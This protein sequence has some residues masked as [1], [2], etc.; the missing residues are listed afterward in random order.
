V[1]TGG[2]PDPA[3]HGPRDLGAWGPLAVVFGL[4]LAMALAGAAV[5]FTI[6]VLG[7]A[8]LFEGPARIVP[9]ILSAQ[10]AVGG[11]ALV[12]G[13]VPQAGWRARL[14][15]VTGDLRAFDVPVLAL[16]TPFLFVVGALLGSLLFEDPGSGLLDLQAAFLEAPLPLRLLFLVLGTVLPALTEEALF[17]GYVQRRLLRVWSAPPAVLFS[18]LFFAAVHGEPMH[19]ASVFPVGLWLGIVA[20]RTGSLW[21]GIAGHFVG[22]L[23][24]FATLGLATDPDGPGW[25]ALAVL[26]LGS[27]PFF[28]LSCVRLWQ[29]G[30][31]R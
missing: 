29:G 15:F 14:G 23:L 26:L 25:G 28:L 30:A 3:A 17:R 21:P 1:A 4:V 24:S 5:A 31:G 16:G 8:S 7:L 6:E 11:L 22:N 9:G 12:A 2:G 20:W 27:L 13:R 10:L 18:S 19:I